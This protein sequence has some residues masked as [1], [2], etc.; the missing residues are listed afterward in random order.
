MDESGVET[1]GLIG[2][3]CDVHDEV[4]SGVFWFWVVQMHVD[5]TPGQ[6]LT[7]GSMEI[8]DSISAANLLPVRICASG[9]TSHRH[10]PRLT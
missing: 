4:W 9:K 7:T 3:Q 6:E 10:F 1:E 2:W 5:T 8:D